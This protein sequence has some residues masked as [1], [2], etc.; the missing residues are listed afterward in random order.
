ME[1]LRADHKPAQLAAAAQLGLEVP[2]TIVTNS[3]PRARAFAAAHGPVVYK[4]LRVT[5]F[6]GEDGHAV[7]VWVD[8]VDPDELDEG[9]SLT[10]HVFQMATVGK[11]ADV[12]IT[13]IGDDVFGVRIDSPN[14][15]FRRDYAEVSYSVF[16][17]PD[18]VADACRAYLARFGLLFGAF[19]F[20]LKPDSSLEFYECNS[21]GQWHWLEG[22]TGL[23]MTAALVDLLETTT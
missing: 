17:V 12:R 11:V 23:P 7:T 5:Q 19:D 13:A 8:V 9:I 4:P 2:P 3:L 16:D 20:G 18:H 22:E 14:V 21:A 10:A 1:H 6:R 15:D